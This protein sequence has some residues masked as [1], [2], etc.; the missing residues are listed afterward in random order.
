VNPTDTQTTPLRS[1]PL[2]QILNREEAA[3]RKAD[4]RFNAAHSAEHCKL[5]NAGPEIPFSMAFQPIVDVTHGRVASYEAL[6]RGPNGEP[7][8][9]ILDRTLHNNRYSIDQRCREKAIAISSALGIL[10]TTADLSV[11]FYPN[12]VYEPKQC[13]QRTFNMAESVMFPLSRIIFEVTE[14]EEVRDKRHLRNIMT[15]YRS[16]GLRVAIDDFGSGLSLLSA[17][18][19]DILKIDR[20][21]TQF[22]DERPASRSIVHSIVQ[23]CRDLNIRMVAEGIEREE[24]MRALCDLGI[25]MMQGYFFARPAFEALPIWP[26]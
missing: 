5:C 10:N 1:E 8:A 26:S 17:F 22:I 19:P 18:Q 12:A 9:S 21:L 13:L 2:Q 6:C 25:D 20:E 16:H 23:V 7:A 24:E 15:E 4:E 11:N 3:I 14:V